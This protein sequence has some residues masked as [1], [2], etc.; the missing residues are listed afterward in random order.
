[1]CLRVAVTRAA[2][3]AHAENGPPRGWKRPRRACDALEARAAAK[4]RGD[5]LGER[6]A[7]GLAVGTPAASLS[8][9]ARGRVQAS[10]ADGDDGF[11]LGSPKTSRWHGL[12]G[13][14]EGPELHG[15]NA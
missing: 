7:G 12:L 14:A 2:R 11:P 3:G 4:P 6:P 10:D 8:A 1:M 5:G 15:M 9:P 13:D